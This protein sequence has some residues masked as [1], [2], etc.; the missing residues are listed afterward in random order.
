MEYNTSQ[1]KLIIP[2][3]G[4]HVHK[5]VEHTIQIQDRE[6]RNVAAHT[7]ISVMGNLMPHLRESHDFKHKLWNHLHIISDFKLDIDAPYPPPSPDELVE[8]PALVPY[9][10][11][12]I[13]QK[14]YGKILFE[15]IRE[16]SKLDDCAQRDALIQLLAAQMKKSHTTWNRSELNNEQIAQDIWDISDGKIKIDPETIQYTEPVVR[17]TPHH[18]H[19]GHMSKRKKKMMRRHQNN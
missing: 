11:T 19:H 8:K 5:M 9:P 13:R 1:K 16:A 6:Q 12:A 17:E 3:Y 2:E 10:Q 14:H 15:M 7:I 4:R 18:H